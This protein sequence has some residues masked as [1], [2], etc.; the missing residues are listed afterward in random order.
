LTKDEP[1]Y[2]G[3][4]YTG[5]AVFSKLKNRF[6]AALFFHGTKNSWDALTLGLGKVELVKKICKTLVPPF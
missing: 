3:D 4:L 5:N 1:L 6:G 2:I